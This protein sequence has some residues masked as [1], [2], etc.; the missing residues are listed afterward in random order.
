MNGITAEALLVLQKIVKACAARPF[1]EAQAE[2]LCPA[3][4]C[5]AELQLAL[6]EL[7]EAGML[8]LRQKLWGRGCIR[9]PRAICLR[10][11]ACCSRMNLYRP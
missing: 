9:F 4:L 6:L 10:F 11:I 2:Q 7:R 3:A 1:A 8:E 5:R